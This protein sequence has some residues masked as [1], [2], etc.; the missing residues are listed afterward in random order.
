MSHTDAKVQGGWGFF[1]LLMGSA[2]FTASLRGVQQWSLCAVL[3]IA[4]QDLTHPEVCVNASRPPPSPLPPPA[5]VTTSLILC[6]KRVFCFAL[7]LFSD[8]AD[9]MALLSLSDLPHSA[10]C[11]QGPSALLQMVEFPQF[12]RLSSV[13]LH[14][15]TMS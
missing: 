15:H 9:I 12:F 7:L 3:G 10:W 1:P 4:S 11:P 2:P 13:P 8:S 5:L 6:S 14:V